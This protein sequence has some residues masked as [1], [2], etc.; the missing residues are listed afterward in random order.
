MLTEIRGAFFLVLSLVFFLIIMGALAFGV[1]MK[2]A[3]WIERLKHT[4]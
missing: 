2:P 4:S 1:I 3:R